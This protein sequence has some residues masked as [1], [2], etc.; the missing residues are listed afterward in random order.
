MAS[1]VNLTDL[2]SNPVSRVKRQA[3]L[4]LDDLGVRNYNWL[5]QI[6]AKKTNFSSLPR[7]NS[8]FGMF[9]RSVLC[10][11]SHLVLA[12]G[13]SGKDVGMIFQLLALNILTWTVGYSK[14]SSGN[15]HSIL[16]CSLGVHS[17]LEDKDN[18]C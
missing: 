17:R 7:I 13:F 12:M 8:V 18:F 16:L 4:P 11:W 15:L 3:R 9:A 14:L 6:Y 2:G 10:F 5:S 1:F